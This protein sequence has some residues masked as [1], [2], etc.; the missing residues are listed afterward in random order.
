MTKLNKEGWEVKKLGEITN[1]SRGLTYSG[2]DEVTTSSNV[3]LR[4]N[5]ITLESQSLNFDELKYIND[6]IVIPAEKKLAKDTIFMCMSNGSMKHIGKV[7][8][9]D[10]DYDYAFGGFMGLMRPKA[11]VIYP[12]YLYFYFCSPLFKLVLAKIANGA[13]INNI[14][15]SD[16]NQEKIFLPP[17]PIQHHIVEE[18]D[19]INAIISAKMQQL[20]KLDELAQSIFYNM[21]GDPVA[22]EKGWEVKT[23]K[24]VAPYKP[25]QDAIAPINGKY[26][27]LNLD[28][29]ESQTGEI[30][31]YQY[32]PKE[33]I[34]NSV[35]TFSESNILYSKLRPY[36]NKVVIPQTKGYC[37]S[38]LIP[39]YPNSNFLLREFLAYLLRSKSFVDAINIKVAG[40][41]MPR[42]SMDFLWKFPTILPPLPLQQ[43]FA[44]RVSAIEEEK[45]AI[46]AS[47]EK[48]QTLLDA[49]MQYWFE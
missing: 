6:S 9:I 3:V 25:Y 49:R 33:E 44:A 48:M 13:N 28:H 39:L 37:T 21:F 12:K 23:L 11:E 31:S 19:E 30:I 41:K 34:G 47:I 2:K 45:A 43:T 22:N 42:V 32:L 1:F 15:F 29:V 27:L 7:A 17:L 10:K 40:A 26:W 14:K 4:S 5:N 46:A 20:S 38:E 16:I 18:L 35:T 8:Y 24:E 36:L